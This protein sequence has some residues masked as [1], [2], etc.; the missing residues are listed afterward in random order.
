MVRYAGTAAAEVLRPFPEVIATQRVSE[1]GRVQSWVFGPGA[2][3]DS[4]AR[5]RLAE[6]LSTELP[7]VVDADGLT[8]LAA[9]PTLVRDR[10]APTV[11]TP[12][13][14]SSPASPVMRWARTGLPPSATSPTPG[15]SLCC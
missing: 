13:A 3:T 8:L 1:A 12:H 15:G 5:K 14:G 11:L 9:E 7:V 4:D 6:V 10:R 2:G